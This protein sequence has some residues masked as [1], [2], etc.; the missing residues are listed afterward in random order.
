MKL[1]DFLTKTGKSDEDFAKEVDSTPNAVRYWRTGERIPRPVFMR[2]ILV[3]TSGDVT[4]NDFHLFQP[5]QVKNET[6]TAA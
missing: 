6:D 2:R 3:A 5:E 4:P 1:S